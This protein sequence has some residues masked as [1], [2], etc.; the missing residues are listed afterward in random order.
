MKKGWPKK[1]KPESKIYPCV[2]YPNKREDERETEE[3]AGEKETQREHELERER[4]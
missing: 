4:E 2:I 1:R 3:R